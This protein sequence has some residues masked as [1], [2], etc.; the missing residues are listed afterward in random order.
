MYGK[1]YVL[2]LTLYSVSCT[3]TYKARKVQISLLSI[4][5]QKYLMGIRNCVTDMPSY[6]WSL[7]DIKAVHLRVNLMHIES[8]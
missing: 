2:S 8:R 1:K 3:Y 5:K 6:K 7:L 4:F